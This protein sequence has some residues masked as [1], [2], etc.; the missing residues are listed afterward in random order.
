MISFLSS[1]LSIQ[2]ACPPCLYPIRDILVSFTP[3]WTQAA[4]GSSTTGLPAPNMDSD[5]SDVTNIK[6]SGVKDLRSNLARLLHDHFPVAGIDHAFAYGSGVLPQPGLY[7]LGDSQAPMV[8]L[9]FV[10]RE[11]VD[12][13]TANMSRNPH[14][15]AKPV[16]MLGP[17]A[18][19]W[20]SQNIGSGVYF[21]AM[22]DLPAS[23]LDGFG[24]KGLGG[25][26]I[27]YGVASTDSVHRDLIEW[28][29]LYVAGRLHKPVET[30]VED[31]R[32]VEAQQRN[33]SSAVRT[34]ILLLVERIAAAR[35]R[36]NEASSFSF[37]ASQLFHTICSL[38]YTGDVRVGIAEDARK[39]D[40][41][42]D[43]SRDRLLDMYVPILEQEVAHGTISLESILEGRTNGGPGGI[44]STNSTNS[45]NGIDALR[46]G[47]DG[48]RFRVSLPH[49]D[50]LVASLPATLR[51]KITEQGCSLHSAL[52]S[53]VRR[54]SA[55]QAA[56]GLVS[57]GP[58]KA[59]RYVWRKLAKMVR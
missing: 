52:A 53:T 13:H 51:Q 12:W 35:I 31:Q 40:R 54:S 39:V 46:L 43:G 45:T 33:L 44:N 25:V 4:V 16:S 49:A 24:P 21:N 30:L 29:S 6:S 28:S 8:D 32:I 10:V 36:S 27:K 37:S 38:S 22:V 17:S 58:A 57:A 14:H 23:G 26:K 19:H 1:F 48:S 11:P 3:T 47:S 56:L 5:A 20:A 42:L 34:A 59:A 18:V 41:I 55:R 50:G 2:S 9:L 7:Q 15:Y